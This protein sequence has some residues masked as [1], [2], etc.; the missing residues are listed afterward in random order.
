MRLIETI[1]PHPHG[2]CSSNLFGIDPGTTRTRVPGR[3]AARCASTLLETRT[4]FEYS[5]APAKAL[6]RIS[7]VTLY[8]MSR[9]PK[10]VM[11]V[12]SDASLREAQLLI[13]KQENSMG[14][15]G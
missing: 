11:A 14:D 3:S 5:L 6:D 13:D 9:G 8:Q 2:H 15:R 10:C 4:T 12:N 7:E 1:S